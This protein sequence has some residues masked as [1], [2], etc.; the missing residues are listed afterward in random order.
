ML[1]KI[2]DI[3][4]KIYGN[5][6]SKIFLFIIAIIFLGMGIN[7]RLCSYLGNK[8]NNRPSIILIVIDTLRPDHMSTYGYSRETTPFID[9]LAK[10][11]I[12]FTQAISVSSSTISSVPSLFTST[13]PSI[14]LIHSAGDIM[15]SYI[16]SLPQ[17]LRK[18]RYYTGKIVAHCLPHFVNKGYNFIFSKCNA[19]ASLLTK[20]AIQWINENREKSFFLWIHYIDPHGPYEPPEEFTKKYLN[21]KIYEENSK[22]IPILNRQRGGLGGIPQYQQLGGNTNLS[23]YISQYDAEI[24]YVDFH[25]GQLIKSLKEIGLYSKIILILTADHG[26][27]IGE[28]NYYFDHGGFLYD[29]LIRVPLVIK[30]PDENFQAKI[31]STQISLIDVVPTILDILLIPKEKYMQGY[32]LKKLI[33]NKDI[34]FPKYVFCE[35]YEGTS[36]VAVRAKEW[37]LIFS[38]DLNT[39]ELYDLKNDPKELIN[40]LDSEKSIFLELKGVLNNWV[41]HNTSKYRQRHI[42]L[43][44]KDKLYLKSLGY[45]Q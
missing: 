44:E 45:L 25:I 2:L 29:A 10:E 15:P 13:Y 1:G 19:N 28:H 43:Q 24:N 40:V 4:K 16:K 12:T 37:K 5:L 17:I 6:H 21:D 14:H 9:Q 32:S 8:K 26:E 36:K 31:I 3:C 41:Q 42:S 38:K 20:E 35:L 7:F 27:S 18:N 39:Y 34:H 23:Y 33:F 11:G 22:T 30:L